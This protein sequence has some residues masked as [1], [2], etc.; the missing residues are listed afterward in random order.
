[1][2]ASQTDGPEDHKTAFADHAVAAELLEAA[3]TESDA[4]PAVVPASRLYAYATGTLH[5]PDLAIERALRGN[6]NLRA[7]YA[8]M[9][10]GN[11]L[12]VSEVAMAASSDAF[13][14]RLIRSAAPALEHRLRV[15]EDRG[16]HFL[17]LELDPRAG[18]DESL[19]LS[20]LD[21]ETGERELVALPQPVEGAMQLRLAPDSPLFALLRRADT[22]LTLERAL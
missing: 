14:G 22:L 10:T 15:V 3:Y 2:S 11:A 5:R 16:R 20:I 1:M 13:P 12:A 19:R 9:I 6:T 4:A 21:G 8:R 7:A 17:V 18:P